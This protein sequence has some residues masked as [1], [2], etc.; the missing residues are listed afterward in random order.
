MLSYHKMCPFDMGKSKIDANVGNG[1]HIRC[2]MGSCGLL[3]HIPDCAIAELLNERW[4]TI[5]FRFV[6]K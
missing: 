1:D 3:I 6:G 5:F 4:S 2:V